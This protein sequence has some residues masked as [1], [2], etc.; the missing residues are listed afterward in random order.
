MEIAIPDPT[1][2]PDDAMNFTV[3]CP[4]CGNDQIDMGKG[5]E[6]KE[7]GHNPMPYHD[8]HGRICND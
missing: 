2:L 3:K 8:E 7:C 4:E 1:G 6:C 5:A